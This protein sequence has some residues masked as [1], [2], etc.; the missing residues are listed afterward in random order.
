MAEWWLATRAVEVNPPHRN[1]S[2]TSAAAKYIM[3]G[4]AVALPSTAEAIKAVRTVTAAAA[5]P[6]AGVSSR[7][8]SQA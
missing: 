4:F 7:S 6:L 1:S 8:R 3:T 2:G 5:D